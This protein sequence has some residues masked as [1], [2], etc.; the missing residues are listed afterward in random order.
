S[1]AENL[2]GSNKSADSKYPTL[3]EA[4]VTAKVPINLLRVR[5]FKPI[6]EP[7]ISAFGEGDGIRVSGN[8]GRVS[9]LPNRPSQDGKNPENK[10]DVPSVSFADVVG[11]TQ[12]AS[13]NEQ[14]VMGDRSETNV[15]LLLSSLHVPCVPG[16]PLN[17]LG[18]IDNLTKDIK[19]G[20]LEVWSDL[21]SEKRT[22]VMETI[23][24]M[25]KGSASPSDPIVQYVDI[26]T[27]STSYAGVAGASAKDQPKVNSNFRPFVADPNIDGVNISV[28]RKVVKR[29][30]VLLLRKIIYPRL[31]LFS[32]LN[33][34]EEDE[35]EDTENVHDES[36]NL[37]PNTKAG[38]SSSFTA[39]AR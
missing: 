25:V 28:P 26:N 2:G 35:D 27:K 18:D 23:W 36:A 4:T 14:Q 8:A 21:P 10:E 13:A 22:E 31:I 17:T 29:L 20:K 16:V 30:L 6:N 3:S 19:L 7:D 37:F 33:D 5:G 24:A 32:A 11:G 38:G 15:D 39:A 9:L 1:S 12:P 34:D